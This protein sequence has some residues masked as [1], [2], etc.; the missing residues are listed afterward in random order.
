[1]TVL[2][3]ANVGTRD[4]QLQDA[5][6]LPPGLQD[7]PH[8][9]Q[10]GRAILE[11][12]GR[13]APSLR[14]PMISACV[15]WL[16]EHEGVDPDHL[17]VHLFASDQPEPPTTPER[18]WLD[19]TILFARVIRHFL[20][21]GGLE[22]ES[23]ADQG[24]RLRRE[25]RPLR[26]AGSHVHIHT[27]QGS[28]ADYRNLLDFFGRELPR[29]AER[30]APEDR[31]YLEVAGG[32]PAMA[33][34]LVVGGVEAFGGRTRTLYLEQG[35]TEPYPLGIESVLLAR[36]LRETLHAQVHIYAYAVAR[37]TFAREKD[38]LS[39]DLERQKLLA[40]VL[41][42]GQ[43]RLAFDFDQARDA[44]S[45]ACEHADGQVATLLRQWWRELEPDRRNAPALLAE[46][47]HATRILYHLGHYADFTQRLFR[48][49]EASFR[50]LVERMGGRYKDTEGKRIDSAWLES[51]PGLLDFLK[52]YPTPD[53]QP[54]RL[55]GEL[56]R[57]SLGALADFF[58]QND[59]SLQEAVKE[60]HRLSAVADL[61]NKGLAGHGFQGVSKGDLNQAFGEDANGLLPLLERIYQA[62]FGGP[63]GSSPYEDLN[64]LIQELL[65][66]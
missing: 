63:V 58:V 37:E 20:L 30:L 16:L 24:A 31:V 22:W 23:P 4:V 29:L 45:R 3:L 17:Y 52:A 11:D 61:R 26:L 28:P 12:Y 43:A 49:Q 34:M 66:P 38:L 25:R 48:F 57:I 50:C 54:L 46:L 9:R 59:R 7:R 1:M 47:I 53:G 15:R 42:Y 33:S 62:L 10:L 51:V 55:E 36:R 27:I 19:D 65:S 18:F 6:V 32:T 13:Y 35:A 14:V 64:G 56:N 21:Q 8:P 44:L 2:F 40:A 5:S 41:E 60:L 39:P